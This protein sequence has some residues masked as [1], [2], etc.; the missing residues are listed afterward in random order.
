MKKHFFLFFIVMMVSCPTAFPQSWLRSVSP[1][2]NGRPDYLETKKYRK[3][4]RSQNPD[5]PL[6]GE[7]QF[8]RSQFFLDGRLG[9]DGHLPT[10]VYWEESKKVIASRSLNR[11]V[12]TPWVHRGPFNSTVGI[13]SG[14]VGGSGRIDC[15][16]FHPTDPGIIYVGTP[17]GGLW[18]TNDGGSSWECLTDM[19]PT[20]GISDIDILPQE[21]NTIFI[22][23][24]S[25]D[26]WW[27]TYSIGILKSEDAGVTWTETGLHYELQQ[28]MSVHELLI[29]PANPLIMVA[30]TGNGIYRSQNGG[31][32]WTLIKG[33]NF[34]DLA[35]KPGDP[36]TIYATNFNYYNCGAQVYRSLD[37]GASFQAMNTGIVTSSV[38]R[39]TIGVTSADPEVVYALC[40][41]CTDN[42]LYGLYKST[43]HGTTWMK[44]PNVNN[45]NLLGWQ[46]NGMDAEGLGWY[47][48]SISVDPADANHVFV[49]GVNIWESVDGGN[50]WT[51]NAQ[52]YGSGAEYVHADIHTLAF[53]PLDGTHYN[54]NDGG[55][56]RYTG[57]PDGWVNISD[58]L[59]IM[60][61]YRV[62]VWKQDAARVL[63]SPQDNGPVLF[64][65]SAHYEL[66]VAEG[67]DNFFD[68]D[69]RDTC[70]YGGYGSG[71]MRSKNGGHS[72]SSI[73]PP[74]V[75]A[76]TFLP[77]FIMHPTDPAILY[78]AFQEVYRSD[79]RGAAWTKLT[80]DLSGGNDYS[81]LEVAPSN[82]DYIYAATPIQ[83]WRSSDGGANW[84]SIKTGLPTAELISDIAIAADNPEHVWVAVAGFSEGLKVFRSVNGGQTWQNISRN[85]PNMPANCL[86][87][88]P[89][90]GN[91]IYVGTD[92][93]VYYTNDNLSE[94]IDYSQQLPTVIIDE[95]EVHPASGKILAATYGRGMWENNLA[96]PATVGIRKAVA[97]EFSVYPNPVTEKI[98]VEFTPPKPGLYLLTIINL[99]GQVVVRK[100]IRTTG[101][102]I[103]S[104]LDVSRLQPGYYN[105]SISGPGTELSRK[106]MIGTPK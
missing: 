4:F 62:G 29:N 20:L 36:S 84:I 26:V 35:Q 64:T 100:E 105:I 10:G 54:T 56:Y 37:A 9:E 58:G 39:I 87:V 15:M 17:C 18:R 49:G 73:N 79:N 41:N 85:L 42:S 19:L 76:Y 12:Q 95:L 106:I 44:T 28:N 30:A 102:M 91:A 63:G 27:E 69:H 103:R 101:M 68:Y 71:L 82:P 93:G 11:A 92:V 75:S 14:Q 98:W 38:N 47:A 43:D 97:Q 7:K 22:C 67:C 48:L 46:P 74:G 99:P 57:L 32:N 55:I 81:S 65:D 24:G 1:D 16:E 104:Q 60:Q 8:L 70:Y 72:R 83:I 21:P 5:T 89:G 50:I 52:Y 77:P 90:P 59:H 23:T 51:L 45:L 25:R 40:S 80:Q 2:A 88:E 31:D 94:W 34:M 3:T 13:N 66:M 53:N 61:F 86:A 33:G 78:T 96:D 6:K